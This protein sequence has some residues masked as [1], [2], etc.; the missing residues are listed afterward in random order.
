[1]IDTRDA[2]AL[3]SKR[4]QMIGVWCGYGFVLLFFIASWPIAEF[5]PPP[6]P[7]LSGEQLLSKYADNITMVRLAMPLGLIAGMLVVPFSI[8]MAIQLA[9][10]EGRI[11]FWGFTCAS[12]GACNAVA[13][14]LPFI[15]FSAGYYRMDRAPDL[16]LLIS[17][18][19]WLEYL[20]VWPPIIM[21]ILCVAIVGLSYKGP[22]TILPRW[23][24]WLSIWIS[25]LIM[26]AGLV[27]FFKSGPFAWNGVISWW[28]PASSFGLYWLLL[29]WMM[30][31]AVQNHE[32]EAATSN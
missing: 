2:A 15:F 17:D 7:L 9:R 24:C 6:S 31:R 14:Y 19:A 28:I 5:I 3:I 1:M 30:G 11:P 16:V 4:G 32:H 13:F 18:M 23:F 22:L 12:A 20:M 8:T 27:I 29:S 21:Q 26:P 25:L 10:L